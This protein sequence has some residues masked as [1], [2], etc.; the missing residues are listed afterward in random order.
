MIGIINMPPESPAEFYRNRPLRNGETVIFSEREKAKT[1]EY[2]FAA[3]G[4][5]HDLGYQQVNFFFF[6]LIILLIYFIVS[7]IAIVFTAALF[8]TALLISANLCGKSN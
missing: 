1:P 6:C 7:V 4:I 3:D 5:R 8:A 2:F